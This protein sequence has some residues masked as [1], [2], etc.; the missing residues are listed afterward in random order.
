MCQPL[1]EIPGRERQAWARLAAVAL[2]A[3]LSVVGG[4]ARAQ[5]A[6]RSEPYSWKN[7]QIVGGGFVDGIVFHPAVPGLSYAR[8]DIGGSYRR[9]DQHQPWTAITDW[10]S[11]QD[12]ALMGP[13]SIA[14]DPGD[15]DKLYIA[16]GMYNNQR[17]AILRSGDRGKTFQRTYVPFPMGGNADGRGNGERLMVDPNDGRVL[18]F[19]S[20]TQGLWRST[21]GAVTWANVASFPTVAG[22]GGGL[23]GGRG[24]AG[25]SGVIF[26][27]YDPRSGTKGKP[28]VT[29]YAGVSVMW[30]E[31]I[32]RSQD[33]GATWSAVPGQP[34]NLRPTHGIWAADGTLY[35]SYSTTAG[36]GAGNDGAV[37]KFNSASGQWTDIT[38]A[39]NGDFGYAAVAV[40]A[41]NP[42]VVIASTSGRRGGEEIYR[43]TDGGKIWKPLIHSPT[44]PCVYD[45]SGH[46]YVAHT[47]IHW[48]WDIEIDPFDA[49]HA[50]FTTGYGGWETFNL[51]ASDAGQAVRWV[52]DARGIE[53]TVALALLSPTD[54]AHLVTA[55]GDYGGFVHWDLDKPAPEGNF[56]NPLF[57]NTNDVAA[58]FKNPNVIVRVGTQSGGQNGGTRGAI[59]Y[60]VDSGKTWQ[61]PRNPPAGANGFI[62]V[63]TDGRR[64]IWSPGGGAGRGGA[65][66]GVA[67]Y[68]T[69]DRGETW[70]A[71]NGLPA[72]TRVVADT[73]DPLKFYAMNLFGG[74]LYTSTDGGANFA[75]SP[76]NLPGG[77]PRRGGNRGD[78]RG[79]QDR[80]YAAPGIEGDLWIAAIDGI[81]HSTDGGKSFERP[82]GVVAQLAAFGFGKAAPNARYPAIYTVA[83]IN[84]VHGVFRSDD[85]ANTWVRINDDDHQWGLILHVTG[86]PRIYGRAYVGTHGRGIFYGDLP[87]TR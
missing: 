35:I 31:S 37:G 32:F 2:A 1:R 75:A 10:V 74:T 80:I 53:E 48:L 40:D 25:G 49:N 30:Q 71:C 11:L 81:Y 87:A 46:P 66:G 28:S 43:T 69:A 42:Q 47:G 41:K 29:I 12:V 6:P 16:A 76:M 68:L 15:P 14:V 22:G 84:S 67:P 7:V 85:I 64:W 56:T 58:G 55:I 82:A 18:Y 26:V 27:V 70:T 62:T 45:Y 73:V 72:G 4:T 86:D 3:W 54:G 21:D 77:G 20:R 50:L 38:P 78:S 36:P 57:G 17:A 33:A 8:T 34:T 23:G 51:T 52:T 60:S 83:T 13:E 5:N 9:D 63:S 65:A 79:G 39:P 59:G 19:G 24:G 44:A 61:P